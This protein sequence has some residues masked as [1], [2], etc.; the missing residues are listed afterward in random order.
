[1]SRY[2]ETQYALAAAEKEENQ[3]VS[4]EALKQIAIS[5][6]QLVDILRKQDK[7]PTKT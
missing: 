2:L 7:K 5:L 4:E 3:T 6:A 1:M